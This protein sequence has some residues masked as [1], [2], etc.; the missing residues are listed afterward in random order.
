MQLS[1]ADC[2]SVT[3]PPVNS[4]A[5]E[6]SLEP[7]SATMLLS[8]DSSATE[9]LPMQSAELSATASEIVP[10]ADGSI[11]KPQVKPSSETA[12]SFKPTI[13]FHDLQPDCLSVTM[14]P[15]NSHAAELSLEPSS[16]TMLLSGDSSAT[17]LLPMQSAELSATASEIVPPADGSIPKPQVKPSSETAVSLKPTISFHDLESIPHRIRPSNK[18]NRCKPPSFLLTS[19]EHFAFLESKTVCNAKKGRASK[20]DVDNNRRGKI[21]IHSDSSEAKQCQ[22]RKVV[23]RAENQG[24]RKLLKKAKT[25]ATVDN[26][27]DKTPCSYCEI[28]YFQSN[29]NWYKCRVCE[30]WACGNCACMGRKRIFTCH[31][32]K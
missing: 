3:V 8:G 17:E 14:P 20:S 13:S 1:S 21:G 25:V 16:A 9:L 7:S 5:A 22:K 6:L 15:V 23:N 4:H 10:P 32:C 29:V 2:L 28:Q 24:K 27:V 19:D 18:R 31:D 12:V 11:P 30:K 26:T